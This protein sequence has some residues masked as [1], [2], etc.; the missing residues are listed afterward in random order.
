MVSELR[1]LKGF[2]HDYRIVLEESTWVIGWDRFEKIC[3]D[4]FK[5]QNWDKMRIV[6]FLDDIIIPEAV[7]Y[8]EFLDGEKINRS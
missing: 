8:E 3:L 2:L 1:M 5:E 7:K 6:I 4:L